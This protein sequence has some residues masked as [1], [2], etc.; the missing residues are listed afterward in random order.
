MACFGFGNLY[1]RSLAF[2]VMPFCWSFLFLFLSE[3]EFVKMSSPGDV[4]LTLYMI[5]SFIEDLGLCLKFY[6]IVVLI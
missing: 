5:Y 4:Y 1:G 6:I 3:C 2:L